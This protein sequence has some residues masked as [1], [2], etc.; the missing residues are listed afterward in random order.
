MIG[1]GAGPDTVY[2]YLLDPDATV[3]PL[4]PDWP[5]FPWL[6]VRGASVPQLLDV[7]RE[8]IDQGSEFTVAAD[9]ELAPAEW[10]ARVTKHVGRAVSTDPQ[11]FR[12]E[13]VVV[14]ALALASIE[15]F[16]RRYPQ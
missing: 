12:R 8:R 15:A 9:D 13:M 1:F 11:T 6:R 10:I 5:E 16:D 3:L 7:V 14:C 4:D 2:D